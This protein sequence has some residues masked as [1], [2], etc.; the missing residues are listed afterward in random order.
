[1]SKLISKKEII[2]IGL[3][4][5]MVIVGI[6]FYTSACLPDKV[7]THWNAQGEVDGYNSKTFTVLF[8]PILTLAIY[9]LLLFI[10]LID[11]L[12]ENFKKFANVYFAFKMILVLFMSALYFYTLFN[13]IGYSFNIKFFMIPAMSAMFIA[14]G[15]FLPKIK[16]NYF[17]GVRTPWTL[18][19]DEVWTETHKFAGKAFIIVGALSAFSLL[20]GEHAFWVF[21]VLIL[22]GSLLPVPYSYYLY[23]KL[24]LFKKK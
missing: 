5:V 4:I 21:I 1:M 12:R 17:A 18:H 24:G 6:A 2:P 13:A 19:S 10:P 22:V 11:P 3:I 15:V 20:L 8:F 7:P 9:L 14:I 23:R 16:R